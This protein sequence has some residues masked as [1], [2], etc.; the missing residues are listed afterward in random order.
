LIT[1]ECSYFISTSSFDVVNISDQI[2]VDGLKVEIKIIEEWGFNLGDDA[3]LYDEDD[4]FVSE[5]QVNADIYEDFEI[6]NNVEILVN[7]I[8]QDLMETDDLKGV[9]MTEY[10]KDTKETTESIEVLANMHS[11]ACADSPV[12]VEK[13]TGALKIFVEIGSKNVSAMG[14]DEG[15]LILS[16]KQ[17]EV[18]AEGGIAPSVAVNVTSV[19]V[20]S[21]RKRSN[22]CTS[23]SKGSLGSWSVD[24]LQNI[25]KGD[26]GL[27][28]SKNMRLTKVVKEKGDGSGRLKNNGAEKKK[29]GGALRHPVITLKKVARLAS[30]DREEVMKVLRNSKFLK[31]L[32]QKIWNRG[33]QKAR[34]TRSLEAASHSSTNESSSLASV[35]NDWKNWVVLHGSEATKAANV[36]CIG[37]AI[38]VSFKGSFHNKFSV[39][40]CHKNVD[41]GPVLTSVVDGAAEVDE[42]V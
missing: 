40:S 28:S 18:T 37:K 1:L 12:G 19:G 26:V 34:V 42:G 41:L 35:N 24:W 21:S 6:N 27:I 23:S 38:G 16:D 30:K 29:A 39:L 7:K 8:R 2:L 32:K 13:S 31:V 15:A 33:R 9:V 14:S 10:V 22:N 17:D 25:Q 3:C 36:Q 4:K 5:S 20:V 11:N